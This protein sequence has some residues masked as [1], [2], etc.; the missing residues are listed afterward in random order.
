M[1]GYFTTEAK[2]MQRFPHD[3]QKRAS[4]ALRKYRAKAADTTNVRINPTRH[5]RGAAI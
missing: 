4:Q 5:L 2:G 3:P 1:D